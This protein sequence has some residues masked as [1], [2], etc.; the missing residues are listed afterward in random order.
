LAGRPLAIEIA[1]AAETDD[2][3]VGIIAYGHRVGD[4]VGNVQPPKLI[5]IKTRL[6]TDAGSYR[7][8]LADGPTPGILPN[9]P[10]CSFHPVVV[11]VKGTTSRRKLVDSAHRVAECVVFFEAG[12]NGEIA[13]N[14]ALQNID[15]PGRIDANAAAEAGHAADGHRDV[16]LGAF[17]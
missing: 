11:R 8:P 1:V 15:I 3:V 5:H 9:R 14:T 16:P 10:D 17:A 12:G 6:R 7:L 13:R 2:L 4:P